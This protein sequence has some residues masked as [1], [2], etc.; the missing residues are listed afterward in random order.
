M[1]IWTALKY[2]LVIF[3]YTFLAGLL[4]D[5]VYYRQKAYKYGRI[6]CFITD[7]LAM[8]LLGAGIIW[9]IIDLGGVFRWYVSG[10]ILLGMVSYY[11]L[12]HRIILCLYKRI[13]HILSSIWRICIS[14]LT[15]TKRCI[16]KNYKKVKKN[17]KKIAQTSGNSPEDA[18]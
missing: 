5:V 8:G 13:G 7:L 16:K 3:S 1:S 18:I 15:K 14:P 4:Y 17:Q 10:A 2:C 9:L 6:G 11:F 12:L